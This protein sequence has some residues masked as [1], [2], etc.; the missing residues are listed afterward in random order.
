M[1]HDGPLIDIAFSPDGERLVTAAGKHVQTWETK[2]G[3]PIDDGYSH[4]AQVLSCGFS[5]D[6]D[7]VLVVLVN[8][9]VLFQPDSDP[10]TPQL[11]LG[12]RSGAGEFTAAE[13]DSQQNSLATGDKSGAIFIFGGVNRLRGESY[14]STSRIEKI[15]FSANGQLTVA[16]TRDGHVIVLDS[17]RTVP[18][19]PPILHPR[20]ISGLDLSADGRFLATACRDGLVRSWDLAASMEH[21]GIMKHEAAVT[22][23]RFGPGPGHLVTGSLDGSAILW[24]LRTQPP[25]KTH[26]FEHS[27]PVT[28]CFLVPGER[29]LVTIHASSISTWNLDQPSASLF[30]MKHGA[31]IND[32]HLGRAGMLLVTASRDRTA[33]TWNISESQQILRL[34][35]HSTSVRDAHI[36]PGGRWAV[37]ATANP[38][39]IHSSIVEVWDGETGDRVHPAHIIPGVVH[40]VRF[41]PAIPGNDTPARILTLTGSVLNEPGVARLWDLQTGE[42][43]GQPMHHGDAINFIDISDDGRQLFTASRD[44]SA[45]LWSTADGSPLTARLEHRSSVL[46]CDIRQDGLFLVTACKDGTTHVWDTR[47]G[48]PIQQGP[49]HDRAVRVVAFSPAGDRVLSADDG[50]TARIWT[51]RGSITDP[52]RARDIAQLLTGHHFPASSNP[53]PL[54]PR[55]I[56]AHWQRLHESISRDLEVTTQEQF[57]WLINHGVTVNRDL[58]LSRIMKLDPLVESS[59]LEISYR[60]DRAYAHVCAGHYESAMDDYLATYQLDNKLETL[61]LYCHLAAYT[62]E[63]ELLENTIP[64]MILRARSNHDRARL[65]HVASLLPDL[66]KDYT[67][68]LDIAADLSSD[69]LTNVYIRRAVGAIYL[70][71]G[72]LSRASQVFR[73]TPTGNSSSRIPLSTIFIYFALAEQEQGN[74]PAAAQLVRIAQRRMNRLPGL[75]TRKPGPAWFEYMAQEI[76]LRQYRNRLHDTNKD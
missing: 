72:D 41:L 40:S 10:G 74:H 45:R 67:P 31:S 76:L 32:A 48:N 35:D 39:D 14:Q 61:T 62:G 30:T 52:V 4:S 73:G 37:T 51:L 64:Q 68:L 46:A 5:I 44:T 19:L 8:G 2:T 34:Q 17:Y 13:V 66:V 43:L 25:H 75:E 20:A 42:A 16:S 9:N 28:D 56:L 49:I 1:V 12:T 55:Q 21:H 54:P 63:R 60:M 23:A 57:Q 22:A 70:R 47:T 50:G 6:R 26:L 24:D 11:V 58:W 36:S 65:L 3:M 69:Q 29:R 18:L 38:D 27:E 59:P 15:R 53:A 7:G 33:A 71:S